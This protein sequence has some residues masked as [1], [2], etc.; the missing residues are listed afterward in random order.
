[1]SCD[2][3]FLALETAFF[4]YGIAGVEGVKVAVTRSLDYELEEK[5]TKLSVA[6]ANTMV[7][8][9]I[10]N[11][12]HGEWDVILIIESADYMTESEKERDR[13]GQSTLQLKAEK[14]LKEQ[15]EKEGKE[16]EKMIDVNLTAD[17]KGKKKRARS[18]DPDSPNS[19]S[20]APQNIAK[21]QHR[22]PSH[23][24]DSESES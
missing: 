21:R 19:A 15:N 4:S 1:M 7:I 22:E 2:I 10:W 17:K 9:A 24:S 12:E 6:R 16:S 14:Y 20:D 23:E 5:S 8:P 3:D 11:E 13:F 18:P